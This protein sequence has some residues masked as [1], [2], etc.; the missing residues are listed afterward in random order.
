MQEAQTCTICKKRKATKRLNTGLDEGFFY[1]CS[2]KKCVS[3]MYGILYAPQQ[4]KEE[5]VAEWTHNPMDWQ[6][7]SFLKLKEQW[8]MIKYISVLIFLMIVF[9]ILEFIV[10]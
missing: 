2:K 4:T 8:K 9:L 3:A 10:Q 7:R 6:G 5:F 1:L